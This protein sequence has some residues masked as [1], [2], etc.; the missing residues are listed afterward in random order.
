MRLQ[1]VHGRAGAPRRGRVC[2]Q[3]PVRWPTLQIPGRNPVTLVPT[4]GIVSPSRQVTVSGDA[5][6]QDWRHAPT[7]GGGPLRHRE[8]RPPRR[9]PLRWPRPC[10]G[11]ALSACPRADRAAR[12]DGCASRAGRARGAGRSRLGSGR[13]AP[14]RPHHPGQ[15]ANEGPSGVRAATAARGRC[16]VRYVGEPTMVVVAQIR[17]GARRRIYASGTAASSS[18]APIY[19]SPCWT[20]RRVRVPPAIRSTPTRPGPAR[21]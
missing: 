19:Q 21:R 16:V 12:R 6:S 20:S 10:G 7:A 5:G 4:G 13:A 15:R 18:P 8:R 1:H 17:A 14:Y 9:S 11:P 2:G 3:S